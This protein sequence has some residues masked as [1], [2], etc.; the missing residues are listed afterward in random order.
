M[1]GLVLRWSRPFPF[2][3]RISHRRIQGWISR[4]VL[5][6]TLMSVCGMEAAISAPH[7]R[8]T[9]L[10]SVAPYRRVLWVTRWDY[11]TPEDIERICYNASS[12]RFT[13]ILFQV[14]GEG[15]AYFRTPHEPWAF[16]LSGLG[17]QKG[18]GV[19][20]GW[21]PLEVA[22][23]EG[24]RR[25]LRVHAYLNVMPIWAQKEEPPAGRG[26]IYADRRD[27]LVVDKKGRPV[28][29]GKVY[30]CTE[31]G[32][33]EVRQHLAQ[34]FGQLA[35]DYP[36][37]GIHLDYIRY[38]FEHGEVG[39]HPRVVAAFTAATGKTPDA[40][41]E[42]WVEFKQD[43][44][45]EVVRA[46]RRAVDRARP[47]VEIS[48]AVI[49]DPVSGPRLACQDVVRWVEEGLVDAV[50]PMIYVEDMAKF[51][52]LMERFR[53]PSLRGRLWPGIWARD[54]NGVL[55]QQIQFSVMEDVRGVAIFAYDELFNGHQPQPRA[56]Q[57]Y[58]TFAASSPKAAERPVVQGEGY[59]GRPAIKAA[60]SGLKTVP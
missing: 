29:P 38:P 55:L 7:L 31:P 9:P 36:V 54:K 22:I 60:P 4:L 58:R 15:T 13:D 35:A 45:T 53:H 3:R 21:D 42:A 41:P 37:D 56:V 43:Q 18:L 25:G 33:P 39:Y 10:D 52:R 12:A 26:Q 8:S 24:R 47:G 34:L 11:S 2:S 59:A 40:A 48:A 50:A 30:A 23:R 32:L 6:A 16:Q 46:I 28:R 5:L 17:V 1:P 14:R 57:V 44:I 49:A 20:P 27:W 19:D 51:D